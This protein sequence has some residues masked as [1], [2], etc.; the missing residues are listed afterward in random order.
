MTGEAG[1]KYDSGKVPISHGLLQQFPEACKAIAALSA[2]GAGKYTW[3]GWHQVP[4]GEQR[5]QDAAMRHFLE[6]CK[7]PGSKDEESAAPHI[8]A[9]IW[10]LMASYE[11]SLRHVPDQS[12]PEEPPYTIGI[13]DGVLGVVGPNEQ[14][15]VRDREDR[16]QT[17]T[18][19]STD[20]YALPRNDPEET[21]ATPQV[22]EQEVRE[23]GP[24]RRTNK[25]G[26]PSR[27]QEAKR[28]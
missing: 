18:G 19:A 13:V 3:E 1:K 26:S 9:A 5:Y 28:P 22:Q 12:L 24:P 4:D 6:H 14:K 23:P 11:L 8:I 25:D 15:G 10:G 17:P 7:E 2:F 21:R 27:A 16:Q 20:L